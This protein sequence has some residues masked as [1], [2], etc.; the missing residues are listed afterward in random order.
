MKN[1]EAVGDRKNIYLKVLISPVQLLANL[2]IHFF[3][4][5]VYGRAYHETRTLIVGY[6][7]MT[8]A[9]FQQDK[10]TSLW[11]SVAPFR[12]NKPETLLIIARLTARSTD[13]GIIVKD[14]D[15]GLY[16]PMNPT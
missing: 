3:K 13:D 6:I 11:N 7:C 9:R 2:Q 15:L 10:K 4:T 12:F 5:V 1:N 16:C 14:D 8:I